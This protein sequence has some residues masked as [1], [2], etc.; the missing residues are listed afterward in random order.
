MDGPTYHYHRIRFVAGG[1]R[2]IRVIDG[3]RV[4]RPPSPLGPRKPEDARVRPPM[5]YWGIREIPIDAT[6]M[7]DGRYPQL[8]G[9]AL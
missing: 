6:P 7:P 4:Q 9:H 5:L 8:R 1:V 2:V 3:E